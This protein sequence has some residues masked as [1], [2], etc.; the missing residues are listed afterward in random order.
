[1]AEIGRN[2][3]ENLQT[4]DITNKEYTRRN[5]II[6]QTLN[7]DLPKLMNA[8]KAKLAIR[9]NQDE[10]EEALKSVANR[11]VAGL[12][13]IPYELYKKKLKT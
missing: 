6:T 1:M 7:Q 4:K 12:D 11:K 10:T 9:I 8:S 3:H 5:K 13:G 2:Y